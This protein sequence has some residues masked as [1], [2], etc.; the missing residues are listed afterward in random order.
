M[1]LMEF[2]I[3]STRRPY[4]CEEEIVVS[5]ST[6][7]IYLFTLSILFFLSPHYSISSSFF[8]SHF[9]YTLMICLFTNIFASEQRMKDLYQAACFIF[10]V[11]YFKI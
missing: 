1:T 8:F 9:P 3:L 10:L 4:T 6:L 2:I 11:S 7:S 5:H